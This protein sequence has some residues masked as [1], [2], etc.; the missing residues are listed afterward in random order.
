MVSVVGMVIYFYHD[1]DAGYDSTSGRARIGILCSDLEA[2][3]FE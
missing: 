3:R 2:Y 1:G